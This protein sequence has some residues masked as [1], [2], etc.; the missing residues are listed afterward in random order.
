MDCVCL[1][2]E[3][4]VAL[5]RKD[6]A[7]KTIVKILQENRFACGDVAVRINSPRTELAMDDLKAIF[8]APVLPN[9]LVVPKVNDAADLEWVS[10]IKHHLIRYVCSLVEPM[11]CRAEHGSSS[12]RSPSSA[13]RKRRAR[14]STLSQWCVSRSVSQHLMYAD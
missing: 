4:A 14:S 6:D 11:L 3:D 13:P 12:L 5:S 8:E 7:R 10:G 1:D 9:T 2:C